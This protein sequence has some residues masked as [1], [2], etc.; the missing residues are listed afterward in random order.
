MLQG[1][2]RPKFNIGDIVTCGYGYGWFDGNDDWVINPKPKKT[3]Q[4][5]CFDKC[6]TMGFYYVVHSIQTTDDRHKLYIND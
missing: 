4:H 2:E 6:C 3:C 1:Q 5:N